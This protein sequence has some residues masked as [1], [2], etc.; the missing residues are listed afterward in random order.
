MG[1]NKALLPVGERTVLHHLA[2]RLAATVDEVLVAGGRYPPVAGP[3]RWI[4]DARSGV[5]PLEGMLS[6]L[7]AA[8]GDDAMV[9]GCDQP[10]IEPALA[11]ALFDGIRG[12][13]AVVPLLATGPEGTCAV[14]RTRVAPVIEQQLEGPD[15]SI[16]GL[17]A[18]VRVRWIGDAKLR[19]VDPELRSFRN[20]NTYADYESWLR[21]SKR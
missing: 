9:A 14:Y 19:A 1:Q 13:D 15:W 6:G 3:W 16:R 20:L 21:L 18:R 11:A 2:E 4:E 12:V 7:R 10:D 5:G 17:L 8:D